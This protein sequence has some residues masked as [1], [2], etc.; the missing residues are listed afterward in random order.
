MPPPGQARRE[1]NKKAS[2]VPAL[3]EIRLNK[4]LGSLAKRA[5]AGQNRATDVRLGQNLG[6]SECDF[7]G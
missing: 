4:P 7:H 6:V 3:G 2:V 1:A 5:L